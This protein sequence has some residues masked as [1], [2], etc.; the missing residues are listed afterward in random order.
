MV[1]AHVEIELRWGDQDAYGH[2]NNVAFA[3]YLEE[4]RVRLFWLGTAREQT[5]LEGYFRSDDPADPKMLVAA[6]HIEFLRVLEYSEHPIT[7]A[8]W[9]G[10]LGGSS[11]EVHY[12]VI[13]GSTTAENGEARVVA[14]AIT[15]VVI[16]NG[17]TMQ[18]QRL[19]SEGRK[20]A[21]QWSDEPLKLGR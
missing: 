1:R 12:E 21:K 17:E 6:Q 19:D 14:R 16:V 20:I 7:I 18:P 4:A 8:M 10:K 9:I 2:I 5:G 13:D 11:I 3:R 15:T